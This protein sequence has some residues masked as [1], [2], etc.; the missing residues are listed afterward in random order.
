MKRLLVFLTMFLLASGVKYALADESQCKPIGAIA[1]TL[2][3]YGFSEPDFFT[4]PERIRRAVEWHNK[5][6]PETHDAF[7]QVFVAVHEGNGIVLVGYGDRGLVCA[8]DVHDGT[9][10]PRFWS[11]VTDPRA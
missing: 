2:K 10:F 8:T 9:S 6:P 3:A 11:Y 5:T 4:D 7:N 1:G